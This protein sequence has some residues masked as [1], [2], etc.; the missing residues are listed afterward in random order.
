MSDY[1]KI[2]TA[3]DYIRKNKTKQPSLNDIAAQVHLSPFH[4]QRLFSHWA[5]TTPKRFLQILTLEHAK[6]LLSDNSLSVLEASNAVGLSSGSR[7]YDH[8]IHIEAVT[9]S[10]YKQAGRGL[11]IAYGIHATPFGEAFIAITARGVCKLSFIDQETK[12]S[13][14]QQTQAAWPEATLHEDTQ[15]TAAMIK[16]MFYQMPDNTTPLALLIKGT[17]FQLNVWQALL[18]IKPGNVATYKQIAKSIG[19]PKASRAVG[20]AIAA[21]PVAVIIPCHRVIRQNGALGEYRWGPTRKHAILS[22][23]AALYDK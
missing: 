21:N 19:K 10:E 5:G 20:T 18:N 12:A 8:F 7:L 11:D 22:R 4:F 6:T 16:K 3:I 15:A 14:C 23:E 9:P 1:D 13:L 2:A 17:N